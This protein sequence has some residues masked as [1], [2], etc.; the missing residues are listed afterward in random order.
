MGRHNRFLYI[1]NRG[2]LIKKLN[3]ELCSNNK[4]TDNLQAK[5]NSENSNNKNNRITEKVAEKIE[6]RKVI[7]C[8]SN[9]PK[10]VILMYGVLEIRPSVLEEYISELYEHK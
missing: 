3:K 10:E 1:G 5:A 4:T 6:E 9:L 7:Y 8:P 2:S